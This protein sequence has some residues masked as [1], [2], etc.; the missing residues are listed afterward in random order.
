MKGTCITEGAQCHCFN[1]VCMGSPVIIRLLYSIIIIIIVF[2]KKLTN[3]YT[4]N[5]EFSTRDHR[6]SKKVLK[7]AGVVHDNKS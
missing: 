3:K 4:K 6:G 5:L 2:Q 7:Q 1:V